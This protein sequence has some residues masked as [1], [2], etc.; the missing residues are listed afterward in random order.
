MPPRLELS[1]SC[2]KNPAFWLGLG[3]REAKGRALRLLL[4]SPASGMVFSAGLFV[5]TGL[6]GWWSAER[7]DKN[8]HDMGL[9]FV[10]DDCYL[11][12]TNP[13]I[14]VV[15]MCRLQTDC[16]YLAYERTNLYTTL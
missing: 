16:Y 10:I 8:G 9:L 2:N 11:L 5:L 15:R 14:K 3:R 4:I 1:L 7:R 12:H 6:D 13:H